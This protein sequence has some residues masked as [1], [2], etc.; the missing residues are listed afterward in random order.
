LDLDGALDLFEH[1]GED[2]HDAKGGK[3]G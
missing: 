3:P 1:H 2:E